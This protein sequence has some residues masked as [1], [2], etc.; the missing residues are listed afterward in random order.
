METNKETR[1]LIESISYKDVKIGKAGSSM[2]VR[3]TINLPG[4]GFIVL[5]FERIMIFQ[6]GCLSW[7][8]DE[9][10]EAEKEK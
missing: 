9:E 7:W 10:E 2:H 3:A 8:Q 4:V 6:L 1:A 5:F